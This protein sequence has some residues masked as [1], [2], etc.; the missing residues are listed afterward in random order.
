MNPDARRARRAFLWVGVIVPVVITLLSSAVIAIWLPQLPDPAATHWSGGGGPDGFGPA[1]TFLVIGLALPLALIALFAAMALFSHRMPPRD[2]NGPQW[3]STARLLGAMSLGVSAM[4]A[5]TMLASV[6]V[7]RGLSDAA[8]APEVTGSVFAGFGVA[9][10]IT[11][12]GWFLQPAV[13]TSGAPGQE[14]V[15]PMSLAPGE[16]AVWTSTATTGR[17]GVITLALSLLVLVA[18]TVVLWALEAASW[19][20]L[21]LVA[22]LMAVLILTMLT[23]RVRV[24]A[25]GLLVR[26]VAGWPRF[27]VHPDDVRSVRAVDV[28]PFA[29]FGGWGVRLVTDG[30]FGVVLRTGDAIEVTRTNGRVFVVTVDDA[31]TGAAL[32]A[33]VCRPAASPTRREESR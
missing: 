6:G 9:I 10:V 32:L 15:T 17:A 1:W 5:V 28:H 8:D 29:E 14:P 30:R 25:D 33:A 31:A 3:S 2:P 24:G 12:A 13:S 7:Q 4:M 27:R 21:G 23:F 20:I 22:A 26:S 11:V 19:W 16:R 18:T